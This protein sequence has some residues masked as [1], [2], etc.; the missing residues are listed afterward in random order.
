MIKTKIALAVLM[1]TLAVAPASASKH[2]KDTEETSSSGK[3]HKSSGKSSHSSKGSKGSTKSSGK[4]SSKSSKS[5][6]GKDSSKSSKSSKP[7]KDKRASTGKALVAGAAVATPASLKLVAPESY[8]DRNFNSLSN[9]FLN[10]LWRLDSESAVYAGKYD[11]AATLSI[12][13]KAGQARALAF[14]DE[15]KMKFAAVEA[16]KLALKQRTDLALLMNKLDSDRFRLTTLKEWEWNPAIYNVAGPIDL[17]LNTE[18]AAQPQRLRTL[19]KRIAGIPAYYEA[20][21]ANLVNPT[22]E[23]TRLAIAQAPGIQTLLTEVDKAAQSSILTPV[24]KQWYTQ[25]INAALSDCLSSS[26][27]KA[28]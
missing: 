4:S 11:T 3:H 19:L 7:S 8:R 13:D 10:A 20:A 14:I 12:P 6:S 25:C 2:H 15:W 21:R 17:I 9:Q 5:K 22:R 23:H 24:E 28:T 18:Y 1:T 26:V 16:N 27:M